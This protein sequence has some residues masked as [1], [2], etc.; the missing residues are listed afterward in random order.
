MGGQGWVRARWS[1]RSPSARAGRTTLLT[2][3]PRGEFGPETP[4]RRSRGAQRAP[5][6]QSQGCRRDPGCFSHPHPTWRWTSRTSQDPFSPAAPTS[7]PS[8]GLG[9]SCLPS[10]TT[11]PEAMSQGA[12]GAPRARTQTPGPL[13]MEVRP[14]LASPPPRRGATGG[15]PRCVLRVPQAWCGA[16]LGPLGLW[17]LCVAQS[18]PPTP[19]LWDGAAPASSQ[20]LP[21][22]PQLPRCGVH[23]HGNGL[24]W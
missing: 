16:W 2:S 20:G 4:E 21:A 19:S 1:P 22:N 24:C 14:T 15:A 17:P 18:M 6:Q 3:G 23:G 7:L 9:A 11:S 5:G 8:L 12:P 13:H 10:P